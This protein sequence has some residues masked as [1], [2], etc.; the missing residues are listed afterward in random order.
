MPSQN[1]QQWVRHRARFDFKQNKAL[2]DPIQIQEAI[3]LAETHLESLETQA[4]HLLYV[5]QLTTT[6]KKEFK[7]FVDPFE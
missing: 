3:I 1:R 6:P 2:T 4:Q 7:K 5:K